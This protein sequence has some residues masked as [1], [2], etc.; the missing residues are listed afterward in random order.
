MR[1]VK[2]H[3]PLPCY[4]LG[5]CSNLG[6]FPGCINSQET[7]HQLQAPPTTRR[8]LVINGTNLHHRT[9][10]LSTE[11]NLVDTPT[12]IVIR[13]KDAYVIVTAILL[14]VVRK[15]CGQARLLS[16][17]FAWFSDTLHTCTTNSRPHH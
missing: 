5:E 4:W 2:Y 13:F 1:E 7:M 8:V 3:F 16:L 15:G 9:T 14:E 12:N 11:G 10:N 17:M 6:L